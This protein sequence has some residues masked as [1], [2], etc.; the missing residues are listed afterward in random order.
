MFLC[1]VIESLIKNV[2]IKKILSSDNPLIRTSII[3]HEM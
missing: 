2:L 3:F 1:L